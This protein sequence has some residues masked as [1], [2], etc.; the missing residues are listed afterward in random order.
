MDEEID[1]ELRELPRQHVGFGAVEIEIAFEVTTQ[2][3]DNF[4]TY[5]RTEIAEAGE[6]VVVIVQRVNETLDFSWR[7]RSVSNDLYQCQL[8]QD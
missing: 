5:Y 7:W 6:S 4:V 2:L 3:V 1:V 8:V